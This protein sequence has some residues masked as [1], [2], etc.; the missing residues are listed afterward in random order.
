MKNKANLQEQNREIAKEFRD[1]VR[2][3]QSKSKLNE[4]VNS[5]PHQTLKKGKDVY[6][7]HAP[8]TMDDV[9]EIRLNGKTIME[10]DVDWADHIWA[11]DLPTS[12]FREIHNRPWKSMTELMQDIHSLRKDI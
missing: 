8:K 9:G 1:M 12:Q 4:N 2:E 6:T 11:G 7:A 3:S 10:T 5:K